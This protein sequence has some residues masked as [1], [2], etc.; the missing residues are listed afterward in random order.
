MV[1][2]LWLQGNQIA[3]KLQPNSNLNQKATKKQPRSKTTDCCLKQIAVFEVYDL[4]TL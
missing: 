3:T 2:G 1:Y 4:M